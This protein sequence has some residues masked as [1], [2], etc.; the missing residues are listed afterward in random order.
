MTRI[1]TTKATRHA[2]AH[3][4]SP[5]RSSYARPRV[6]HAYYLSYLIHAQGN[7]CGPA[8]PA[9][10]PVVDDSVLVRDRNPAD[11]HLATMDASHSV[12]AKTCPS[13]FGYCPPNDGT[14]PLRTPHIQ[15]LDDGRG[16][17]PS[18]ATVGADYSS[19]DRHGHLGCGCGCRDVGSVVGGQIYGR[20]ALGHGVH[21]HR[22]SPDIPLEC[23]VCFCYVDSCYVC[24]AM[25]GG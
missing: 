20:G 14:Y 25:T 15:I 4:F 11:S 19:F 5:T 1:G 9:T 7:F 23:G 8:G 2:A 16:H 24:W 6:R 13:F 18:E 21:D 17:Q 22:S 3:V 10:H 12:L